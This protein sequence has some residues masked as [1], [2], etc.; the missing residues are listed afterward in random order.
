MRLT[1]KHQYRLYDLRDQLRELAIDEKIDKQSWQFKYLDGSISKTVHELQYINIFAT[2][3]LVKR[4]NK[5]TNFGVYKLFI[6]KS[7]S[8]NAYTQFIYDEY[9]EIIFNYVISKHFIL[10]GIVL[11]LAMAIRQV[12]NIKEKLK[13]SIGYFRIIPETSKVYDIDEKAI[14]YN[15]NHAKTFH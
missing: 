3:F 5:D 11:C 6:G 8:D 2:L 1:K 14:A 7:M 4:Y 10:L 12:E 15:Y 13:K 9:G